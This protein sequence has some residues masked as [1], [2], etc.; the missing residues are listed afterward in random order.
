MPLAG[1]IEPPFLII[2]SS[3]AGQKKQNLSQAA[4]GNG[5]SEAFAQETAELSKAAS[6]LN[7][8]QLRSRTR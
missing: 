6:A 4:F 5:L 7:N 8:S 3:P 2:A 1:L